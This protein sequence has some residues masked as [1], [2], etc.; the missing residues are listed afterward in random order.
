MLSNLLDNSAKFTE[1]G[2][3]V[4]VCLEVDASGS[5]GACAMLTVRDTGM[6]IEPELLPVL[7][8]VFAQADR[9][10]DRKTGGLGLGLSLVRGLVTMHGGEV[11]AASAG[12]GRGAEFTIRLPLER[13]PPALGT[14]PEALGPAGTRQRIL[15]IEDNRDAANSLRMVLELMGHEV[16][17]A[18]SGPE[19]VQ[20]ATEWNPDTVLSDLGLPG[21]DGFGVA[22]ELRRNPATAR[23]RLIAVTGYGQES[24]RQLSREVGFEAHLTKPIEPEM[25]VQALA[26]GGC[27]SVISNQ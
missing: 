7:F 14:L 13:E 1:R 22:R 25:L 18:Y 19:G 16:R 4:A 21:L 8:D 12:P 26:S 24:D 11:K 9:S 5:E 27:Q 20:V 23:T 2:G 6:G 3:E 15:I 17:I 10:L